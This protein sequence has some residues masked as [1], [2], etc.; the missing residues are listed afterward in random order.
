MTANQ[1]VTSQSCNESV[2]HKLRYFTGRREIVNPTT[3]VGSATEFEPGIIHV[4]LDD[5]GNDS[6]WLEFTLLL[7][8]DK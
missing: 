1:Q 7:R 5:R 2:E 8:H 3:L 4:R 6:F